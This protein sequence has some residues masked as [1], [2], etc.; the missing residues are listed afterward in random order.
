[1]DRREVAVAVCEIPKYLREHPDT[2]LSARLREILASRTDPV[3]EADLVSALSVHRDLIDSWAAY[4]EDLR[5]SDGW[6][7]AVSNEH[8]RRPEWILARPGRKERLAFDNP[9]AAYAALI[10]RIVAPGL[11][12]FSQGNH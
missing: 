7:V 4:V 5:T 6:F 1:M 9:I 12:G 2:S 11:L 3:R 8:T 10:L